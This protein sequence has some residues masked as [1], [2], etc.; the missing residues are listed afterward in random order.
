MEEFE[1]IPTAEELETLRRLRIK[2]A[3]EEQLKAAQ[4]ERKVV[5]FSKQ[6]MK[7]VLGIALV[8]ICFAMMI[9]FITRDLSA[10]P[11]LI[12]ATCTFSSVAVGFYSAKAAAENIHKY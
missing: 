12:T 4:E 3:Q 10:L 7:V 11:T 2:A 9:M 5:S 6:I 8:V 1:I